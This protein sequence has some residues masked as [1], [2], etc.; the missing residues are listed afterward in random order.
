MYLCMDG[1]TCAYYY[2]YVDWGRC[3]RFNAIGL[4]GTARH[5]M[6]WQGGC[7]DVR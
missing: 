6:V 4:H 1:W 3:T 2:Y 7:E 5:G